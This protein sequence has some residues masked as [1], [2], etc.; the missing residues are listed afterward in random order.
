M[1]YQKT[2]KK[3]ISLLCALAMLTS[4]CSMFALAAGNPAYDNIDIDRETI[5]DTDISV[6]SFNLMGETLDTETQYYEAPDVRLAKIV[7]IIDTYDPDV[8]CVQECSN[9]ITLDDGTA[10]EMLG[11]LNSKLYTGNGGKYNFHSIQCDNNGWGGTA[12]MT[13]RAGLVIYFKADRFD[14]TRETDTATATTEWHQSAVLP[15]QASASI[16]VNDT[17]GVNESKTY[18]YKSANITERYYQYVKLIDKKHNDQPVYVFNTQLS[19]DPTYATNT[20]TGTWEAVYNLKYTNSDNTKTSVAIGAALG[21]QLRTQQ[22]KQLVTAVNEKAA[23]YPVIV[24][25]DFNTGFNE[26]YSNAAATIA[27]GNAENGLLNIFD[28]DLKDG[29]TDPYYDAARMALHLVSTNYMSATSHV[30]VNA[31]LF[32]IADFRTIRESVD[33]RRPSDRF[34]IMT[35]LSYR[36]ATTEFGPGDYDFSNGLYTDTV[37]SSEYTFHITPVSPFT[38]Q[39]EQNGTVCSTTVSLSKTINEYDI[40]FY[41]NGALYDTVKAT[42]HYTGA[43]KPILQT[44]D[45]LNHYFANNAYHVVVGNRTDSI[46]IR[47]VNGKLY[48]D[49]ACTKAQ[50]GHLKNIAP[51]RTKYFVG[52]TVTG[53]VYPLYVYKETKAALKNEM[54]LYV[55]DDFGSAVGTVAFWNGEDVSLVTANVNAFDCFNDL[56][57][58]N[59]DRNVD[60]KDGYIVYVAPGTYEAVPGNV[61]S[62]LNVTGYGRSLTFLGP[63]YDIEANVRD[64]DGTWIINPNRREEAVIHGQIRYHC[65]DDTIDTVKVTV[66]GFKFT[67]KTTNASLNV[68]DGRGDDVAART[69]YTTEFDIENNIFTASGYH[70]NA[71]AI[72]ANTATRKTGTIANNYFKSAAARIVD[73]REPDEEQYI[74][75]DYY[76]GIFLRNPNGLVIDGNR[77][78]DIDT[79]IWMSSEIVDKGEQCM[80]NLSYTMQDNRFENCGS[81]YLWAT[82]LA[83]VADNQ[84][85]GVEENAANIKYYN[86]EFIRCGSSVGGAAIRINL[87]EHRLVADGHMIPTDY[88]K[89]NIDIQGNNFYDCYQ[90]IYL[91]RN[92]HERNADNVADSIIYQHY[93]DINDMTLKI[94][95]NRFINPTEADDQ[96]SNL[97]DTIHFYFYLNPEDAAGDE[98][99]TLTADAQSRWDLSHN[100]F[101]SDYLVQGADGATKDVQNKSTLAVSTNVHD[102]KYFVNNYVTMFNPATDSY[103]NQGVSFAWDG[104]F[105]PYYLD[106][107]LNTL[108]DG[109]EAATMSDIGAEDYIAEYDGQAHGITVTGAPEGSIVSYSIDELETN[110]ARKAYNGHCPTYTDVCDPVTVYYKVEKTGMDTFYGEA[111]IQITPNTSPRDGIEDKAVVYQYG[112]KQT[113]DPFTDT[114]TEDHFVYTYNGVTYDEMPAFTEVGTYEI[115]VHVTNNNYIPFEDTATLTITKADLESYTVEGGFIGEYTGDTHTINIDPTL[116]TDVTVAYS[117][118]GGDWTTTAPAYTIPTDGHTYSVAVKLSGT[119]YVTRVTDPFE[120]SITPAHITDVTVTAIEATATGLPLDLLTVV[121]GE[122]EQ[123]IA[124]TTVEYSLSGQAVTSTEPTFT[125]PGTYTVAVLFT[126]PYHYDRTE[127]VQVKVNAAAQT[128]YFAL[129]IDQSLVQNQNLEVRY[130]DTYKMEPFVTAIKNNPDKYTLTWGLNMQ[131]NETGFAKAETSDFKI[132]AFGIKYAAT[133][134]NLEEY[135]FYKQYGL[136]NETVDAIADQMITD[137]KVTEYI[138]DSCETGFQNLYQFNTYHVY[139]TTPLKARYAML[140]MRYELDGVVYEEYS[141]IAATS[142]LLDDANWQKDSGLITGVGQTLAGTEDLYKAN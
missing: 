99:R 101:A 84:A 39:I 110:V 108:S 111:T 36:A 29:D 3:L 98:D 73:L 51:G 41:L 86:N 102:P 32:D 35:Q 135:A 136:N 58:N 117:I 64:M 52:D 69:K 18:N 88:S 11:K 22:I 63:N 65:N 27:R 33:G 82:N 46:V 123:H 47:P 122:T 138:Y 93:G 115:S 80:G 34:P 30:F 137:K 72:F 14:F 89:I 139:N 77:F 94:T 42:V 28:N 116:P 31:A 25:G 96:N 142:T 141:P 124:N 6:M 126:R 129:S 133:L 112:T 120:F 37:D 76:R 131:F 57:K 119:N 45:A 134:D 113:L 85:A 12:K 60:Q 7:Q 78:V 19:H 87:T 106:D 83:S 97:K 23:Q 59:P 9:E 130:Q 62:A 16:T 4:M 81:A 90:S 56:N 118:D 109:S 67:G 92:N 53:D 40:N 17:K 70:F 21:R 2:S 128:N 38:V 132:V 68:T 66:K 20:D 75:N 107:A 13:G 55:D 71:A 61:N 95:E 26:S 50:N 74:G 127:V 24:A 91:F 79:P 121:N 125:K 54:V 103:Y 10:Y 5:Y 105:E 48:T 43:D 114:F 100:Y 8:V 104:A 49:E 44:E 1:K 140:F 15:A